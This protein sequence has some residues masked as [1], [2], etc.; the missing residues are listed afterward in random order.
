MAKKTKRDDIGFHVR[1]KTRQGSGTYSK[2][3]HGGGETFFDNHRSG[4]PP[5]KARRRK[6]PYKGQGK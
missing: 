1:K 5:T 6:K 2:R 3:A 4:S